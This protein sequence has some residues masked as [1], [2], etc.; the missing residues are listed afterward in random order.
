MSCRMR[1]SSGD[2]FTSSHSKDSSSV[3]TMYTMLHEARE[4]H[5]STTPKSLYKVRLETSSTGSPFLTHAG[6][7]HLQEPVLLTSLAA[8]S[9]QGTP[10]T[11]KSHGCITVHAV[12]K[13]VFAQT[14]ACPGPAPVLA[15]D[16]IEVR[17]DAIPPFVV[18]HSIIIRQPHCQGDLFARRDSL[19]KIVWDTSGG[20]E[21]YASILLGASVRS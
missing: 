11:L 18:L 2:L 16:A 8:V 15:G 17:D 10:A 1:T 6:C 5:L 7:Q 13:L 4:A 9:Q 21:S 12:V 3:P 14:N 19:V 20:G